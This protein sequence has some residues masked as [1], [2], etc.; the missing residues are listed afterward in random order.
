MYE[1]R[2]QFFGK[3]FITTE[4]SNFSKS[5][6]IRRCQEN[7]HQ[8]KKKFVLAGQRETK[9]FKT[10]Y[11][12]QTYCHNANRVFKSHIRCKFWHKTRIVTSFPFTTNR[13][14]KNKSK[15][16]RALLTRC[17]LH[18]LLWPKKLQNLAGKRH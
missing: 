18:V 8:A 13:L 16:S 3:L 9:N 1:Q 10:F 12:D 6:C 15:L 5:V 11:Y 7:N 17:V 14:W 4:K 2:N